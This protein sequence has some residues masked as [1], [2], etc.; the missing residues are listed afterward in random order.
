MVAISQ[1][2][3]NQVVF[4]K[5]VDDTECLVGCHL[6]VYSNVADDLVQAELVSIPTSG[7]QPRVDTWKTYACWVRTTAGQLEN[8]RRIMQN[9]LTG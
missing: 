3:R 4:L 1:P 5:P 6:G 2:V 9:H 7:M 8:S